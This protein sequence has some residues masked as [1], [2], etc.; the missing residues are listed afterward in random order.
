MTVLDHVPKKYSFPRAVSDS[1]NEL[2]LDVENSTDGESNNEDSSTSNRFITYRFQLKPKKGVKVDDSPAFRKHGG[3]RR[4]RRYQN[5]IILQTLNEEDNDSNITEVFETKKTPLAKLAENPEA[6][7]YWNEFMDKSE[8]EQNRIIGHFNLR[9][10][11][12]SQDINKTDIPFMRIS[13]KIRRTLKIKKNLSVD[14]VKLFEVDLLEFFKQSPQKKYV[15]YPI[16]SFDRLLT[17][18]V[19]QYHCLH[20]ISEWENDKRKVEICNL[21]D[22]WIPAENFLHELISELKS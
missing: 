16:T 18:A 13:S 14:S 2:Q 15:K 3:K 20:S 10:Q 17:H 22:N 6:L 21:E 12:K 8:E 19:A 7:K 4:L 9:N 11:L 1:E 5:R